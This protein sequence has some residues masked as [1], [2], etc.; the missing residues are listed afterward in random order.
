MQVTR[1]FQLEREAR[2]GG[3]D[4]YTQLP[5]KEEPSIN[6][7]IYIDQQVSRKEGKPRKTL[8]ITVE[9]LD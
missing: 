1:T 7:T 2:K 5:S 4:R 3:G 9:T 6:E 8:V